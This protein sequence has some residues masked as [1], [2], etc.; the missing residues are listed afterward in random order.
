[1]SWPDTVGIPLVW[2]LGQPLNA[3]HPPRAKVSELNQLPLRE[4]VGSHHLNSRPHTLPQL[5]EWQMVAAGIPTHLARTVGL[6]KV[7]IG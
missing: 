7:C 3:P 1:M 4:L 5:K 2:D 6:S